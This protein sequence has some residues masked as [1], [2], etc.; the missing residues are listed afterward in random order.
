MEAIVLTSGIQR[1]ERLL[2]SHDYAIDRDGVL[3][4]LLA[5][6]IEHKPLEDNFT[7]NI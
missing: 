3:V 6:I 2:T 4:T 1:W 7:N 5:L